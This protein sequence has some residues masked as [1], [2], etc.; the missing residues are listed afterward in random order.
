MLTFKWYYQVNYCTGGQAMSNQ[1][2]VQRNKQL[3]ISTKRD[4]TIVK[5]NTII[6]KARFS[7]SVQAQKC[8]LYIISKIKPK[9][10]YFN[11]I[12]FKVTEFCEICGLDKNSGANLA[13][14]KNTL[15]EIRDKSIWIELADGSETT[16]AWIDKITLNKNSGSVYLKM[17]DSM[18]PFLLQLENK[19]TEYALIYTLAMRSQYSIRMYEL[20]KSYLYKAIIEL[21]IEALKRQLS[22]EKYSRWPDFKRNVLD[23]A[24]KEIETYSDITVKYE[25]IKKGRRY[26]KIKFYISM[27][28]NRER[29]ESWGNIEERIGPDQLTLF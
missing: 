27:K 28:K 13:Y 19:F 2:I 21:D 26:E 11:E 5:S 8:I 9:D 25:I 20:L 4:Y 22:A 10:T 17:D 12:E 3:D 7:L 23:R 14:I 6:Q 1:S 24:M 15:K 29:L 18:K 16:F